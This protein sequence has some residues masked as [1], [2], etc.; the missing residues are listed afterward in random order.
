MHS[1]IPRP[2]FTRLGLGPLALVAPLAAIL[3]GAARAQTS[4]TAGSAAHPRPGD[5]AGIH[6]PLAEALPRLEARCAAWADGMGQGE[7]AADRRRALPVGNGRVLCGVG[8][9]ARAA[10]LTHLRGPQYARGVFEAADA[11]TIHASRRPG[12][13]SSHRVE[14]VR[15]ASF[16]V[17]EDRAE[18]VIV[19]TLVFAPAGGRAFVVVIDCARDVPQ[20]PDEIALQIDVPQARAVAT[21]FAVTSVAAHGDAD[22]RHLACAWPGASAS[23][24]ALRKVLVPDRAGRYPR[25]VVLLELSLGD[26]RPVPRGRPFTGADALR[27]A[28]A[29][30]EHWHARLGTGE[31][32]VVYD[33]DRREIGD[34]FDEFA[35]RAFVMQCGR[36][37]ALLPRLDAAQPSLRANSWMLL[38][39]LRLNQFEAVRRMLE[40]SSHALRTRRAVVDDLGWTEPPRGRPARAQD[41][42]ILRIRAAD[43]PSWFVLQHLWYWRAT[44]D[45]DL[46]ARHWA[47]LD[48]CVRAQRR[49]DA[50]RLP[51]GGDEP[52][53]P[54][55]DARHLASLPNGALF[56]LSLRALGAMLGA[57]HRSDGRPRPQVDAWSLRADRVRERVERTFWLEAEGR[58]AMGFDPAQNTPTGHRSLWG[59]LVAP[60]AGWRSSAGRGRIH[61]QS[62]LA[63]ALPDPGA[64][65]ATT[66]ALLSSAARHAPPQQDR[67]VAAL[68]RSLRDERGSLD[69]LGLG[70]DTLAF[71]LTGSSPTI[72]FGPDDPAMHFAPRLPTSATRFALRGHVQ[73]QRRID[74]EFER[75]GEPS[76]GP[77]SAPALSIRIRA[78]PTQREIL[79]WRVRVDTEHAS[80]VR[81]LGPG[82]LIELP[83]N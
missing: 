11:V 41:A 4:N 32:R 72:L 19:R 60:L 7:A 29:H 54:V 77:S 83:G 50:D 23:A 18:G 76:A 52:W 36:S 38:G 61:A 56:E 33:C 35:V 42:S 62:T 31:D 12:G 20:G 30:L 66:A 16:A 44:G 21:G 34:V 26:E 9:G 53:C 51:F 39:L 10:T 80:V 79:P 25:Q 63:G 81:T 48:A 71:A 45:V 27:A 17:T 24:G 46:V 40:H 78:L 13:S 59:E 82:Q 6:A 15:G 14:S 1:A 58:F 37:G 5:R 69:A 22:A 73:N 65:V 28:R 74:L 67:W 8:S 64:D 55:S 3:T 2:T 70:V 43:L 49:D 68:L 57:R 47:L 75:R